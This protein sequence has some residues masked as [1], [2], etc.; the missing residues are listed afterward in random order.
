MLAMVA[1]EFRW[2][3]GLNAWGTS[4][5]NAT[6]LAVKK[7]AAIRFLRDHVEQLQSAAQA[8]QGCTGCGITQQTC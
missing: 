2:T 3:L 1:Q 7:A 6:N 5:I 8:F 4:L